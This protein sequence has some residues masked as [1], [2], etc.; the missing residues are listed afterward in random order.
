[1]KI[2]I[3]FLRTTKDILAL[4]NRIGHIYRQTRTARSTER[5]NVER[6]ERPECR[7]PNR[8]RVIG[9]VKEPV[10][11]VWH[12]SI[13]H[14]VPYRD[15]QTDRRLLLL[16]THA[17]RQ[18]VDISVTV[19]RVFVRLRIYPPRTKLA[20]SN[21]ARRFIDVQGREYPIFVNLPSQKPKIGRVGQRACHAHPHVNTTVEMRRRKRYARDAPFV[22]LRGVWT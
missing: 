2:K 3:C 11:H 13:R 12:S 4:H 7:M 21:F 15:R 9:R 5:R 18:G 17:D 14:S 22:K 6:G 10:R 16:S 20:A 1:M 19:F 8:L